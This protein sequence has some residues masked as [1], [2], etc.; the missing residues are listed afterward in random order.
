MIPHRNLQHITKPDHVIVIFRFFEQYRGWLGF[1]LGLGF[2][3]IGG[4]G[5]HLHHIRQGFGLFRTFVF[6]EKPA[7]RGGNVG[8]RHNR[9]ACQ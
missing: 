4:N 7:R 9:A 5:M 6:I 2:Q 8:A 1:A 3:H